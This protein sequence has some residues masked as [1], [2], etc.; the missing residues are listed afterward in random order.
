VRLAARKSRVRSAP[1]KPHIQ[2]VLCRY[3]H[4]GS[5]VA[6]Q[7]FAGKNPQNLI[8]TEL[9]LAMGFFAT[10]MLALS[11]CGFTI[12]NPISSAGP[13]TAFASIFGSART[14]DPVE[15]ASANTVSITAERNGHLTYFVDNAGGSDANNGTSPATPFATIAKVNTLNLMPGQ[16]VAFKAGDVWHEMLTISHSGAHGLPITYT[17][18]GAG[19]QPVVDASDTVTG[20]RRGGASSIGHPSYIWSRPQPANPKLINFAGQTGTPVA[21]RADITAAKQFSW[22]GANL[23]VYSN[24]EPTSIVEI[25][26]RQSALT[27]S[28]ASYITVSNLELRGGT[29]IAFCGVASPCANWDF[30]RNTF[31]SGYGVGLR[32]A[33]NSGVSGGSLTVNENTFRGTG[34]SGIGLG[35]GG[36]A[37]GD[38]FTNNTMTDLCKVFIPG[39]PEN[40]YC[41]AMNLFSQTGTDGGGRILHNTISEV[42]LTSGAAYGGGIHPDTVVNWDI[43][44]NTISDTNYPGIEL[45]KGSGSIARHNLLMNTGQYRY[46]AGLFI[47]AGDGLSVSNILAEYN[48]VVGGYWACALGISQNSGAVTATNITISRNICTGASSGTQLWLDPGF[49]ST[50]NSFSTNGF[51]DAP[52]A[53][54]KAGNVTYRSSQPLPLPIVGSIWGDPQ[55]VN[56]TAGNYNLQPTSP[57]LA[58]GA[59]PKL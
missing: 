22:D 49:L 28:G 35:N 56:P 37:M 58:I 14:A 4:L 42:G 59:R 57:V 7:L 44:D 3:S 16:T 25:A 33:L 10:I 47:R 30:E 31:D 39:S 43:E 2:G 12:G 21:N 23:Y 36:S 41:D 40:A 48:T 27:S 17:S 29:D 19:H 1:R 20:W 13:H 11:G 34:S 55:F 15:A 46:F 52:S 5:F 26:A 54:I 53:S 38:I 51:G 32:W 24:K 8:Q 6:N 9:T 45:E 50:G 18:Y